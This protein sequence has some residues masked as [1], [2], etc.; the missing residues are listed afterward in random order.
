MFDNCEA[1]DK[2]MGNSRGFYRYA[3]GFL[4]H[5]SCHDE[6][7][8]DM[9]CEQCGIAKAKKGC[10]QCAECCMCEYVPDARD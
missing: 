10:D 4:F 3:E 9:T 6:E 5:V 1:C 8:G 7:S 2:S